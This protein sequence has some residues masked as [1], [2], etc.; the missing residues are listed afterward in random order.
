LANF[1]R[2]LKA[3]HA[4]SLAICTANCDSEAGANSAVKPAEVPSGTKTSNE[5][6]SATAGQFVSKADAAKGWELYKQANGIE[7]GQ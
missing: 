5:F 4:L 2:T 3:A 7:T 6:Q 1:P